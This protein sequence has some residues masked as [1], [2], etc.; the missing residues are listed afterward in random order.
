MAEDPSIIKA[1]ELWQQKQPTQAVQVL[2]AR[3]N[4]LAATKSRP[5]SRLPLVLSFLAGLLVMLIIG[6]PLSLIIDTSDPAPEP[7]SILKINNGYGTLDNPIPAG[8][9]GIFN[10][11]K[12]QILDIRWNAAQVINGYNQFNDPPVAGGE[13]ALVHLNVE[14]TTYTCDSFGIDLYLVDEN[15]KSWPHQSLVLENDLEYLE[16]VKDFPVDGQLAVEYP[17]QTP[18]V[19]LRLRWKKQTLYMALPD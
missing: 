15:G 13:Y 3:I 19:A 1:K 6:I 14:C 16:I 4:E 10:G 7:P 9:W 2:I 12:I 18:I 17:K 5:P 8:D 11:V